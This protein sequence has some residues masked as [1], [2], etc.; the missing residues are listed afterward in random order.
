MNPQHFYY[1][2]YYAMQAMWGAGGNHL[3]EWYP[4]AAAQL[5]KP[6]HLR[7]EGGWRDPVIG[8]H[9]ATAMACIALQVPNDYLP[10]TER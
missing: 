9:Y 4:A 7:R 5:S 8:D 1:G 10:I 6:Q 2:H 3:G